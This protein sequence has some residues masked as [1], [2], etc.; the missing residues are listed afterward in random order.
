MEQ[1]NVSRCFALAAVE[2]DS[3]ELRRTPFL[4]PLIVATHNLKAKKKTS[5]S[6]SDIPEQV[7]M[8]YDESLDED[9]LTDSNQREDPRQ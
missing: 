8:L 4:V 6:C 9:L 5:K 7:K 3:S 2:C 1:H